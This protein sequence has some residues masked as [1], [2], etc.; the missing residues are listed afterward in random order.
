MARLCGQGGCVLIGIDL[1]KDVQM[2]CN[3][4]NDSQGVTAEF[5]LNLLRRINREL[6]ADFDLNQFDH[7]APYCHKHNR[8]EM[9][10]V[11]QS[12]QVVKIG[13]EEIEFAAGETIRTEYSHKYT[14]DSFARLSHDSGLRV[15]RTWTDDGRKFAVVYLIR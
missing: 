6:G 12:E 13:D 10:L 3:A 9:L 14:I 1:Q 8:I 4:Y 2:I 11:S 7:V 15:G 5:N